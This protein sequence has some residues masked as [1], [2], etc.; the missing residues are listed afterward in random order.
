VGKAARRRRQSVR[1]GAE[2][3]EVSL[4]GAKVGLLPGLIIWPRIDD[5]RQRSLAAARPGAA[6]TAS[7]LVTECD[8]LDWPGGRY[9]AP[10]R[11]V[12][13]SSRHL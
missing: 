13:S 7:Q 6:F 4:I 5:Q 11:N 10:N 1:A 8:W 2:A 9:S 12:Y 3:R